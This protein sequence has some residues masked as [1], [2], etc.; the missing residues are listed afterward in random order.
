MSQA[1]HPRDVSMVPSTQIVDMEN[2]AEEEDDDDEEDEEEE[3]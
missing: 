3:E 2:D 1:P